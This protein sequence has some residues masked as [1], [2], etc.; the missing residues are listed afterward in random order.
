MTLFDRLH[1]TSCPIKGS[2]AMPMPASRRM[3]FLIPALMALIF[4]PGL[5]HSEDVSLDLN[6][7]GGQTRIADGTITVESSGYDS[8]DRWDSFRFAAQRTLDGDG[9]AIACLRDRT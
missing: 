2:S 9:Q 4:N 8:W 7:T 5:A 1:S 3:F 6:S